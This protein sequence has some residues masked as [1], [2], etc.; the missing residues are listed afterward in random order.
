MTNNSNNDYV[1]PPKQENKEAYVAPPKK[2]SNKTQVCNIEKRSFIKDSS[3]STRV[4][5]FIVALIFGLSM[6]YKPVSNI[7]DTIIDYMVLNLSISQNIASCII[8][9]P[10][11]AGYVAFYWWLGGDKLYLF[12]SIKFTRETY[13]EPTVIGVIIVASICVLVFAWIVVVIVALYVAYKGLT[14]K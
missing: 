7:A 12:R 14:S 9:I 2:E 3:K 10:L 11:L 8:G 6:T 13:G 4:W 1:M 5:L